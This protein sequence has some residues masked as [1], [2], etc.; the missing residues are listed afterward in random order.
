MVDVSERELLDLLQS[1]SNRGRWG[2]DDERGTLNFVTPE[3]TQSATSGV[4]DGVMIDCSRSIT[5][6]LLD[7]GHNP[8]IHYMIDTGDLDPRKE[9]SSA[10]DFI[11][12]RIHGASITHLDAHSH[13]FWRGQSYNGLKST[14]VSALRGATKGSVQSFSPGV[15]TRGVLLDVPRA[16]GVEW[17]ELGYR[18]TAEDIA[19]C[20]DAQS[21]V[22]LPGDAVFIRTGKDLAPTDEGERLGYGADSCAG[23]DESCIP[24]LFDSSISI[25]GSDGVN[26][27]VPS[28]YDS[29]PL[30]V[31]TVGITAMGLWLID[32][33]DFELLAQRCSEVNEWSFMLALSVLQLKNTTGCPVTPMAIF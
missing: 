7:G 3:V 18:I 16:L 5:P 10:A 19:K 8:F 31:H 4:K 29:M 27:A 15:V 26:D 6:K 21:T 33:A 9:W 1:C 25:L 24:W 11:G 32:N 14:D 23:L 17:L 28:R 2:A 13:F 12:I 20:L 30:P 22:I